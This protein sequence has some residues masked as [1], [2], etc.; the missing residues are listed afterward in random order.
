MVRPARLT[1]RFE[2]IWNTR[3]KSF[4]RSRTPFQRRAPLIAQNLN[5]ECWWAVGLPIFT[6]QF[7]IVE[8]LRGKKTARSPPRLYPCNLSGGLKFGFK[9]RLIGAC[10]HETPEQLVC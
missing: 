9:G 3:Q 7:F 6:K 4:S 2:L 1:T 5:S 10:A 8:H